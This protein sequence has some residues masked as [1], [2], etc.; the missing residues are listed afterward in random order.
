MI[1]TQDEKDKLKEGKVEEAEGTCL[2]CGVTRKE[3]HI[4]HCSKCNACTV[5]MDH[6]CDFTNT[7]IGKHNKR[8]FVQFLVWAVVLI[9]IG[10]SQVFMM[11][12]VQN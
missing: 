3:A 1:P 9:L 2:K 12:Y 11:F 7:C 4:H 6:H 5:E 10:E 8:F